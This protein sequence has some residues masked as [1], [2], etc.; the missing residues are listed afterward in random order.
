MLSEQQLITAAKAPIT[1]YNDKNWDAVKASV[2]T[3][4]EYDEVATQ[5]KAQGAD[6]VLTVEGWATPSRLEGQ[7]RP[8]HAIGDRSFELTWREPTRGR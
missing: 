8:R 5:R 1:A 7:L 6:A 2:T 4:F 3:G